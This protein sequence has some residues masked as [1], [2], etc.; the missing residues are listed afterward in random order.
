MKY[1]FFMMKQNIVE[2]LIIRPLLQKIIVT[3]LQLELLDGKQ[4]SVRIHFTDTSVFEKKYDYRK[5]M[6]N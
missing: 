1:V 2:K 4:K 3:I 6:G 5:N